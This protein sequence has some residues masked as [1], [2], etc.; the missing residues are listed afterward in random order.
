MINRSNRCP[1]RVKLGRRRTE[2]LVAFLMLF[3]LPCI[4][5]FVALQAVEFLPE[6]KNESNSS[7]TS[8]A[9][10]L[11]RHQRRK[12]KTLTNNLEM[13][14]FQR[15]QGS[16]PLS[17]SSSSSILEIA[18]TKYEQQ[19]DVLSPQ[20]KHMDS[21][22]AWMT[23]YFVWHNETMKSLNEDHSQ[24]KDYQYLVVRCLKLDHKCGGASDRLQS[25][26]FALKLAARYQRLLFIEW[27]KPAPLT[28]YLVPVQINWS[29][30]NWFHKTSNVRETKQDGSPY[31][32]FQRSP[33]ILSDKHLHRLKDHKDTTM[34]DMRYQSTDHGRGYYD[35]HRTKN[36]PGFEQ[37]YSKVWSSLFR[38]A[39]NVQKLIDESKETLQLESNNYNSLHM[40]SIYYKD[41]SDKQSRVEHAVYCAFQQLPT[42][43][44]STDTSTPL[45][46]SSDSP[47]VT[48]TAER[49]GTEDLGRRVVTSS[50][51]NPLHLDRG[52]NFLA[53]SEESDWME[54]PVSAYYDIFVDLYLLSGGQCV[55]YNNVGGY[56]RWASRIA[57]HS[58]AVDLKEAKCDV[59][60]AINDK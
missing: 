39:P 34:F 23:E 13:A 37:V 12:F 53:N 45:F 18:S 11:L 27:E 60:P 33:A 49:Y 46:V 2:K 5:F 28:E 31:M 36:E 56:G 38:P 9:T 4:F 55:I 41:K 24:W 47:K 43:I 1:H 42:A 8:L 32:F 48:Q 40:R 50:T 35:D 20:H 44:S 19:V 59:P 6:E 52:S 3:C 26:P 29:I 10:V 51:T 25:I 57:N 58:C 30:P 54:H 16:V 14:L 21:L 22:P 17:D 7:A 15:A